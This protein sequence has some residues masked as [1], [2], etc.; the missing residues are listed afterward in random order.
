MS[1]VAVRV[2]VDGLVQNVDAAAHELTLL[3]AVVVNALEVAL[4]VATR[5][6]ASP[7]PPNTDRQVVR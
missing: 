4:K 5:T 7:M 6:K 3:A 2:L 1:A